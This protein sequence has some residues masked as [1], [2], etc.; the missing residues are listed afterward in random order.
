VIGEVLSAGTVSRKG[1]FP[2]DEG[3]AWRYELRTWLT[4][5]ASEEGAGEELEPPRS[6][7]LDVRVVGPDKIEGREARCLEY[8]L[9]DEPAQRAYF[10]EDDDA[11]LCPKRV[12]G[13][14]DHVH[15]YLFT[16]PQ[17]TLK[18]NLSVGSKWEWH[19]KV[20]TATGN[21]KFEVLR[22]ERVT[23]RAKELP[24]IETIVV[25][26]AV[27]NDDESKGFSTKWFAPGYGIVRELT[28]V[29]AD[30][31]TFRTEAVLSK[32]TKP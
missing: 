30:K 24:K 28:E 32:I 25:K 11:V 22:E 8:K 2:L 13:A 10:F 15:D 20:G 6:H 17:P 23:T 16:P 21:Q 9:D 12:L 1:L 14:G 3:R 18:G 29:R 19:G 27:E 4:P 7:R 5:T 31:E 26:T